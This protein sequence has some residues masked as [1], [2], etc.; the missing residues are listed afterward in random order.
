MTSFEGIRLNSLA[1][2]V[3]REYGYASWIVDSEACDHMI[4]D[5]SFLVDKRV[6]Y[7]PIKVGLPDGSYRLVKLIGKVILSEVL[8]LIMYF[9]LKVSSTT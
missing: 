5:E 4:F 8:L 3:I 9:W 7:T 1:C 6:L 2:Y